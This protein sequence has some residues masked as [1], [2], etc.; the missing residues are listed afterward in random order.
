M[1]SIVTWGIHEHNSTETLPSSEQVLKLCFL[2][3]WWGFH[4][5]F[6]LETWDV[7]YG[8]IGNQSRQWLQF[9]R[10]ICRIILLYHAF[11]TLAHS[12]AGMIPLSH[13]VSCSLCLSTSGGLRRYSFEQVLL[14]YI[15]IVSLTGFSDC[16][17]WITVFCVIGRALAWCWRLLCNSSY[18][19]CDLWGNSIAE[20]EPGHNTRE[21]S[22]TWMPPT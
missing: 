4:W 9:V 11:S 2:P 21:A 1:N 12:Q 16:V 5:Y 10:W 7:I 19:V 20:L 3:S 17:C 18:C 15:Y 8:F 13:A 6:V 14:A 22:L